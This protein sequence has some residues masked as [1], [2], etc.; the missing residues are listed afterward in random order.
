MSENKSDEAVSR[1]EKREYS[2]LVWNYRQAETVGLMIHVGHRLD[3]FKSLAG[4]GAVTA[5][6]QD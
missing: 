3:L 4:A 2:T 6:E 5:A 1:N